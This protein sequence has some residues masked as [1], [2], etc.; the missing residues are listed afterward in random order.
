M[1]IL[2]QKTKSAFV[3]SLYF[4]LSQFSMVTHVGGVYIP[5]FYNP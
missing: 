4:L 2:I 3:L 1:A 5:V